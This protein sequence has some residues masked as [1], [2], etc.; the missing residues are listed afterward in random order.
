VHHTLGVIDRL[1]FLSINKWL[2]GIFAAL[3]KRHIRIEGS[4]N[5]CA[6]NESSF[7]TSV[8]ISTAVFITD[9]EYKLTLFARAGINPSLALPTISVDFDNAASFASRHQILG[10]S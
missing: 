8:P 7:S 5:L 2:D 3:F 9:V 1:S 6:A 4:K 10:A